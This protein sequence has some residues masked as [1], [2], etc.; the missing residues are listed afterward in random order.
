MDVLLRYRRE[1]ESPD[2][3]AP[4]VQDAGM[5]QPSSDASSGGSTGGDV[6]GASTT[7][8][9]KT[10]FA[11]VEDM[12]MEQIHKCMYNLNSPGRPKVPFQSE[13]SA[14]NTSQNITNTELN[15]LRKLFV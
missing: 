12:V 15:I 2:A 6:T 11:K 13:T 5:T 9:A 8:A 3:P 7:E 10:G 1:A 14:I 4:K